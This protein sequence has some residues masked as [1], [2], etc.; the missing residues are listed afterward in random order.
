MF[1]SVS[2]EWDDNHLYIIFCD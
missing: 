1:Y 2:E